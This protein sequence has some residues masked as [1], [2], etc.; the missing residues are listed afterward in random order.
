MMKKL[1][2]SALLGLALLWITACGEDEKTET[3]KSETAGIK[4]EAGKC[5]AAME[6]DVAPA[7]VEGKYGDK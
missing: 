5:A 4:C 3:N 1:L 6:K 7:T 2:F